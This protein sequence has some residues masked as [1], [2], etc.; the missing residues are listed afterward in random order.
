MSE[1]RQGFSLQGEIN[2]LYQK[3][4]GRDAEQAGMD[5]WLGTFSSGATLADIERAIAASPEAQQRQGM[6]TQAVAADRTSERLAEMGGGYAQQYFPGQ[7]SFGLAPIDPTESP[8]EGFEWYKT[9]RELLNAY[10]ADIEGQD[11]DDMDRVDR[12]NA[13]NA[14]IDAMQTGNMDVIK[15][16]DVS[17]LEDMPGFKEYYSGIVGTT[18]DATETEDQIEDGIN[19]SDLIKTHGQEAVDAIFDKAGE[20]I[21]IIKKTAK[22]PQAAIDSF[23]GTF[24]KNTKTGTWKDWTDV[25]IWGGIL[26][27]PLPPGFMGKSVRDIEDG[28]KKIGK[29]IN[30]LI[31]KPAE[32]IGELVKDAKDAI[33]G[34]FTK[35]SDP[36]GI[37][38]F[39][40]GIFGGAISGIIM[41]EIGDT[42]D[43]LLFGED[44][45]PDCTNPTDFNNNKDY[46]L[47]L[48]FVNCDELTGPGGTELTGGIV[49]G[50]S[51]C[52]EIGQVDDDT[53]E[54]TDI[55]TGISEDIC[56]EKGMIFDKSG[57]DDRRDADGCIPAGFVVTEDTPDDSEVTGGPTPEEIC[58]AKGMIFDKAGTDDR[59][60][61]D[62]CVPKGF[63]TEDGGDDTVITGDEKKCEDPKALNTGEEGDCKYPSGDDIDD[64][65]DEI[66]GPPYSCD[67]P[68]ATTRPDG[69]CGP[70]KAGYVFDG[71][72]ERCVQEEIKVTGTTTTTTTTPPPPPPPPETTPP[73][74]TGG[75]GG[76]G[77]GS[78]MMTQQIDP[79][80]FDIAGDPQLLAKLEFPVVDYLAQILPADVQQN[81]MKGLF[82][83]MV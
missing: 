46:C 69:S 24:G 4:L 12:M 25:G 83:G 77:G 3:Y 1:T 36:A 27:I 59:R 42:L 14:W 28:L 47:D 51:N 67:D 63:T 17:A 75:G 31:T 61:A 16:V 32:T 44:K 37:Y 6:L 35:G 76:G 80:A 29:T 19:V 41:N 18:G 70:C 62:G 10:L 48:G 40:S 72:V 71:A 49:K 21:D 39:V 81:V 66:T 13:A 38:D 79:F 8:L 20:A 11:S 9:F 33:T 50:E 56:E 34:V 73:P 53:T 45:K 30:D 54:E 26:G 60:D 23:I 43:N 57:T 15:N 7:V 74:E 64:G 58:E 68:N 82:E 2:D 65:G 5:H 52:S 78:G 22:D 55:V